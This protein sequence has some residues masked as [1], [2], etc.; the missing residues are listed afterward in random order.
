[1]VQQTIT[2]KNATGL[3]LRPTELLYKTA[4]RYKAGARLEYAGGNANIK[5]ILSVLGSGIK[6]GDEV[7]VQCD[8]A[9]EAEA[10]AELI[11]VIGEG[12]GE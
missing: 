8:G 5:S 6:C 12:L 3:S 9:D 4:V 1:M 7:T 10:L 2:I 11:K